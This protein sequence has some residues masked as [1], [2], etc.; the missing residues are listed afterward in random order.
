MARRSTAE[1]LKVIDDRLERLETKTDERLAAASTRFEQAEKRFERVSR[2]VEQ[3]ERLLEEQRTHAAQ[4][5]RQRADFQRL[6]DLLKAHYERTNA[7]LDRID[8]QNAVR[9]A[10]LQ[11]AIL[12]L[13]PRARGARRRR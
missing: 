6:W 8:S 11:R 4:M 9:C 5:E 2:R 1:Y 12:A 10:D 13:A 7:W 3:V